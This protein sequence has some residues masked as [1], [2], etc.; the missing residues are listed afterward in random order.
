VLPLGNAASAASPFGKEFIGHR[1]TVGERLWLRVRGSFSGGEGDPMK[2]DIVVSL[3]W[4]EDMR[5]IWEWRNHPDIR[6]NFFNTAVVPWDE[7]QRWFE[8]KISDSRC[9]I[10]IAR[11]GEEKVGVIRFEAEGDGAQVS[12]H[13]NPACMGQGLGSRVIR[14]GT[15]QFLKEIGA[16]TVIARII[17]GNLASVKAFAKAGYRRF[18]E[19]KDVLTYRYPDDF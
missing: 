14:A 13:L 4:E 9:R 2:E 7:H 8:R 12:V 19:D 1:A 16:I 17:K 3:A 11:R 10:Y 18:S 15:E 6:K 5:D